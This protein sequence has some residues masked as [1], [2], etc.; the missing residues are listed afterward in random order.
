M[1]A[2]RRRQHRLRGDAHPMLPLAPGT[3]EASPP[4]PSLAPAST[5]LRDGPAQQAFALGTPVARRTH[6][7]RRE[8]AGR[9]PRRKGTWMAHEARP[10]HD[11]HH[12]VHV[13]LRVRRGMPRLRRFA[14][15]AAIGKGLRRAAQS[16]EARPA[17]RRATFRVV[18]FSIQPDHLHLI[19]EATSKV[20]LARGMQGVASGLARRVNRALGRRGAL[21]ADRYHAHALKGPTEVR[22]A[23]A[24][25]LQ[26]FRK[27]P[28]PIPDL[29]TAPIAGLDPCSSARWFEGWAQSPGP[30]RE[31]PPVA[32]AQTWLLRVGWRRGRPLRRTKDKA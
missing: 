30:Q 10:W 6:G 29:G 22:N 17:M 18:H 4:G 3:S 21:F 8:G 1:N 7:G 16:A 31:P 12:P 25:V 23:I 28:E 27:H 26:N 24:Y 5:V 15:A 19:V 9:K 20:A 13:T 14:L 32:P 2:A 11:A